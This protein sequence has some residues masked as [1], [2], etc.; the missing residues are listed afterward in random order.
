MHL[1]QGDPRRLIDIRHWT[2]REISACPRAV[3]VNLFNAAMEEHLKRERADAPRMQCIDFKGFVYLTCCKM[4]YHAMTRQGTRMFQTTDD[5]LMFIREM[6]RRADV[7]ETIAHYM[8]VEI[9]D[10]TL[11]AI[12]RKCYGAELIYAKDMGEVMKNIELLL[13]GWARLGN[14]FSALKRLKFLGGRK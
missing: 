9:N 5:M 13:I 12:A 2:Y 6:A 14:N 3:L 1:S 4:L 11:M 7:Q 10:Y 8:Q